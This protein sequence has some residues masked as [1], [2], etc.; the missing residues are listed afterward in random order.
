VKI[1]PSANKSGLFSCLEG[2]TIV[3]GITT[4]ALS[5]SGNIHNM[6]REAPRQ[7]KR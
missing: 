7:Q 4:N 3:S 5:G 6:I 2:Q 1:P